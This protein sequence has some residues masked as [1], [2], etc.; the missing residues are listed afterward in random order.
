MFQLE[1]K[2]FDKIADI[3]C[4]IEFV[5]NKKCLISNVSAV[6]DIEAS[7]FYVD[8]GKGKKDSKKKQCCMYAWVFGINGKCIRGRT[9]EEFLEV[10]AYIKDYYKLS[11]KKI[12]IIY[13][14]N[15]AYEFQWFKHKFIWEKVFN[16]ELRKPIYA[17][18]VD[19]IE[20]R[21]SYLLSGMSLLKVG[22]NLLKYKVNKLKGD[23]DYSLIRHSETYLTDKEW[24]YI[25]NDGLVV[26]A[27]IQ[28]E[29]ERM[30][31]IKNIP[32]TKTGYVRK[33]CREYCLKGYVG[34]KYYHLIH[35][36]T[37]DSDDYKQ[38]KRAFVGG[39][40]HANHNMV[41]KVFENVE[42]FDMTSAYPTVMLSEKFPMSRPIKY[43]PKNY[44]DF[45][46]KLSKYNCIFDVKFENIREKFT[47]EHYISK[48]KCWDI[49]NYVLDNGRVIEADELCTTI[50]EVDFEIIKNTYTW[51]NIYISNFKYFEKDYLPRE[52]LLAVLDLYKN[53]TE[54]KGVEGKEVEYLAS[55]GMI[56]SVYGMAVTDP[57]KDDI[58]YDNITEWQINEGDIVALIEKYNNS[59]QR[60]LYYAWGLYITA[61]NRRNLWLGIFECKGD[62]IYSDT[63]S[64][65]IIN[66]NKHIE[67]FKKY[68][69]TILRKIE[70]CLNYNYIPKNMLYPK[71]IKGVKKPLGVF[72]YECNYQ[73][74]K[75]LG[76]K[77][78]MFELDNK[79]NIT[80]SGVAKKEGVEYLYHKF[81]TNT[82]IF[83]NFTDDLYFPAEYNIDENT[84][85][86]G[87]GKLTHTYIDIPEYGYIKDYFGVTSYYEE[88]SGVH[89]EPASYQLSLDSLFMMYITND[90]KIVV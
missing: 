63:D 43:T 78:Y 44:E 2:F 41:N 90:L 31:S 9:W 4:D 68:N 42:S 53:K 17:R 20:F 5:K 25:L 62:Y 27:Y 82:N 30:G 50:T 39:F 6:F 33:L 34:R 8:N 12:L 35:K 55:K 47:Y 51:D 73:R 21:C 19:G 67:W 26:M 66:A 36:L 15:L 45:L 23:L 1:H 65:K 86:L 48:S 37:I 49:K 29:I 79:I 56:N 70:I 89:M 83:N 10:L 59:A 74:F 85:K 80:I 69:Q 22:E 61:Y 58:I 60:F 57:C 72:E 11:S 40:T 76:A 24:G 84:K 28:E 77:R 18:T 64:L 81:K 87:T 46:K 71:T 3:C 32:Y 13:V 75:T 14:H 88:D 54:L 52:L 7:S 38:F 16:I